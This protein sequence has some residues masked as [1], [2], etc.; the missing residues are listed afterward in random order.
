MFETV[1]IIRMP[2]NIPREKYMVEAPI[3]PGSLTINQQK[4]CDKCA[5][6]NTACPK[7]CPKKKGDKNKTEKKD[8]MLLYFPEG[9][10]SQ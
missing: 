8:P 2:N 1:A 10:C 5:K 7:Y 9:S 6:D 4:T 3:D